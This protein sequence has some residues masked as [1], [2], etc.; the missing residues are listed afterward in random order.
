MALPLGLGKANLV[1]NELVRRAMADPSLSLTI[2]TAL[3]LEKPR[4]G[5]GIERRFMEPFVERVFGGYPELLYAA[6]LR[7]GSLPDNI[8][9]ME[10]FFQAGQWLNVPRAQQ[11][12]ISANYTHAGRYVLD[13]GVNVVAQLVAPGDGAGYSLSCNPDLTTDLLD[14]RRDGRA[15]F[16]MV[17]EV[18]GELPF[19]GGHAEVPAGEFDHVL[20]GPAAGFPLFGPPNQPVSLAHYAIGFRIA[21]LV[22]DGGTLQIGIGALGDSIAHALILRHTRNDAY[23]AVLDALEIR[24]ERHDEPFREGLYGC[25]EMIADAFLALLE[26]GVVA[27][28]VEGR[29]IHAAFFLGSRDFY[30]RLRELAPEVRARIGMTAV[31]YVNE[32]YG[33]EDGKRAARRHARFA[34]SAMMATLLGAAVSDGLED[35]RVVSGIGG[36][37]N[38]VAQAFALGNDARSILAVNATRSRG[39]KRTSNILWSYGHVS[40]PRHL[41]D[42]VVTEYGIADLRGRCDAEVAAAMLAVAD[43]A[44]QE[45][46]L[47]KAKAAGKLPAAFALPD[48]A[49][50]NTPE[51]L[52][53]ALAPLRDRGLLPPF[54]FGTDFTPVEQRLLPALR[55]LQ[56]A[57]PRDLAGFAWRGM[58]GGDDPAE[59]E[60]LARLSLGAPDSLKERV[61]A[62]LVR[63]A[64]RGT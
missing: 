33:G 63:G 4:A 55:R 54:P 62:A 31:T 14:A 40:V 50:A 22:P 53:A 52:T 49:R 9:V 57:G 1:A 24:G 3:T 20:E 61:Y 46:L 27:R 29:A 23:R 11:N 26:A 10:F 19:M 13:A 8:R 21:A 6:A 59:A 32:L 7:D 41:R 51:R 35:G 28:E 15:R 39:G 43:A 42:M 16:L 36:Q 44:F 12:Y 48:A 17:G 58:A 64:M 56:G 45:P 34:N 38:F 60:A 5:G 30:R 18:N 25:S 47:A 37:Y 2:I